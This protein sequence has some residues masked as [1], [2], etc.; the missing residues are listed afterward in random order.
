VLLGLT[1]TLAGCSNGPAESP[2]PER[3]AHA[4]LEGRTTSAGY[5]VVADTMDWKDTTPAT[6]QDLLVARFPGVEVIGAGAGASVRIRGSTSIV[7]NNEPLYVVDGMPVSNV[8]GINPRDVAR[9]EVL[10]DAGST[11]AYGIQGANGV[12]LITTRHGK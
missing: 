2:V 4:S 6:V 10:K 5:G 1:L 11:A 9:I 12:I 3:A 7:G 8:F